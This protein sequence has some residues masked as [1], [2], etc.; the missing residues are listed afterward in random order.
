MVGKQV[1]VW[2]TWDAESAC[3]VIF[4]NKIILSL[5]H[6]KRLIVFGHIK[7]IY[8]FVCKVVWFKKFKLILCAKVI[9]FMSHLK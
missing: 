7:N 4:L 6:Y 5:S 8:D 3:L 2:I 1:L 9:Y